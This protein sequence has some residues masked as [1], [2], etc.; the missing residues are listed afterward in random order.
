[1]P[2]PWRTD[3]PTF[4]GTTPTLRALMS[5]Y[6]KLAVESEAEESRFVR[7]PDGQR[8]PGADARR[9]E[10]LTEL[11]EMEFP[12]RRREAAEAG[13][14]TGDEEDLDPDDVSETPRANSARKAML[15]TDHP[16]RRSH[17]KMPDENAVRRRQD[18]R[19]GAMADRCPAEGGFDQLFNVK[20]MRMMKDQRNRRSTGSEAL[21]LYDEDDV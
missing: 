5:A 14:D 20:M 3:V 18:Q 2:R 8:V 10:R 12:G 21:E 7:L 19:P 9:L 1:M 15:E 16:R 17:G 4:P 13:D 6:A 11:S